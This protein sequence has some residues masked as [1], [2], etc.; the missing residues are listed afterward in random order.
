MNFNEIKQKINQSEGIS[1]GY[2]FGETL[3]FFQT[4]WVQ[5][6]LCMVFLIIAVF[7]IE[8]LVMFPI[9]FFFGVM[10]FTSPNDFSDISL[11]TI[12]LMVFVAVTFFSLIMTISTSLI[13]GLFIIYKK[14]DH[15]EQHS[16]NDFFY[17]M[18]KQYFAKT[19]QIGLA[20]VVLMLAFYLMCCLPIIYAVVPISYIVVVYAFNPD[21]TITEI[22]KLSFAIGNKNWIE[23]FLLRMVLGILST[24]LGL[25]LCGVGLLATFSIAI[26][27]QYLIYKQMIGFEDTSEIDLIGTDDSN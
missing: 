23:K 5:G 4:A 27:P 24:I 11:L 8:M 18:K 21:L 1:F 22:V 6:L 17:L 19:F 16:T 3:E 14:I 9:S 7:A 25:L 20:Q 12:L 10:Q 13:G 26:I 2:I 15:D